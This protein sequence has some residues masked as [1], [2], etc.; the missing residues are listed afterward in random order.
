MEYEDDPEVIN[1]NDEYLVGS[2]ILVA[3]VTDQGAV[4]RSIYLPKGIWID[5]HSGKRIKGGK[6]ILYKAPVSICPVFIKGG[7]ILPTYPDIPNLSPGNT[8]KLI[9][10]FYP[11]NNRGGNNNSCY[12]MHYQDNGTDFKYQTGGYNLYKFSFSSNHPGGIKA[13]LI[14]NGYKNK[15]TNISA[16]IK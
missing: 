6:Y 3:P 8:D 5:Y 12:Y 11:S 10:E 14:K 2:S 4:V 15:Y 16:V 1:C 9:V 13:I 7:S